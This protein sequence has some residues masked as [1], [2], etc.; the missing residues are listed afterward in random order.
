[1]KLQNGIEVEEEDVW[2]WQL[3]DGRCV[4]HP[5]RYAV[6]LHESPPKSLD[7]HWK[8]HPENRFPVCAECHEELHSKYI[9][10]EVLKGARNTYYPNAMEAINDWKEK[11]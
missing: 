4:L 5:Y 2:L 6:C 10:V 7:P 8:E 3:Y 11:R 1:M 9:P